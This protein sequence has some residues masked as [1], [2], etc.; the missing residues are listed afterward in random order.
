MGVHL[1]YLSEKSCSTYTSSRW[2]LAL[3]FLA[4]NFT[5]HAVN[6]T[7]YMYKSNAIHWRVEWL[8]PNA[9][10]DAV[11]FVDE[12]IQLVNAKSIFYQSTHRKSL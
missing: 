8:F 10:P 11:K 1:K 6:T 3:Q 12:R 7:R 5:R 9:E 4:Q 2:R